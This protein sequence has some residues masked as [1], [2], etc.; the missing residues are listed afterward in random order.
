MPTTRENNIGIVMGQIMRL[1]GQPTINDPARVAESLESIDNPAR[2]VKW[3]RPVEDGGHVVGAAR[4]ASSV[5]RN[6]R[7]SQPQASNI[8]NAK[9]AR[10]GIQENPKEGIKFEN[11]R[12]QTFIFP[13]SACK[14]GLVYM[15]WFVQCSS[16]TENLLIKLSKECIA[17]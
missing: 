1:Q 12:G 8:H 17:Y 16:R 13:F 3:L 7:N 10:P 6:F 4:N 14:I 2:I 5:S 15:S 11:V 9:S